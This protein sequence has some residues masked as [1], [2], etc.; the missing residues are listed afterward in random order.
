M[1]KIFGGYEI[2]KIKLSLILTLIGGLIYKA[3]DVLAQFRED[4]AVLLAQTLDV[5]G[6]TGTREEY[7][8]IGVTLIAGG[9]LVTVVSLNILWVMKNLTL[10]IF[11]KVFSV[12]ALFASAGAMIVLVGSM[13]GPHLIP[14]KA[15]VSSMPRDVRANVRDNTIVI[16]WST[17]RSTIGAIKIINQAN[18]PTYLSNIGRSSMYHE[19]IIDSSNLQSI[20]FVVLSDGFEY[21][22]NG[23]PL[24]LE[25]P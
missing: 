1:K 23:L 4:P 2:S 11:I 14:T 5:F 17:N 12:W 15:D 25:L 16:Q 24:V 6:G 10:K 21:R 22:L 13:S 7:I 18:Q 3:R 19:V 9:L 8:I 20:E